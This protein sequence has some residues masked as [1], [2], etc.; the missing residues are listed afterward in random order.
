MELQNNKIKAVA[1][2][3]DLR[4]DDSQCETNCSICYDS[5]NTKNQKKILHKGKNW[6]HKFHK[7]CIDTWIGA[8]INS[9]KYPLCPICNQS[10]NIDKIQ[11]NLRGRAIELQPIQQQPPI[12]QPPIQQHPIQQHPFHQHLQ[13]FEAEADLR[14]QRIELR[15]RRY[16]TLPFIGVLICIDGKVV[17]KYSNSDFG[18]TINSRLGDLK[19]EIL[20]KNAEISRSRGLL[21]VDNLHHN[22]N[23]RN[24][25]NGV[26]PTYRI[27]DMHY[28]IPPFCS[29]FP[30]LNNVNNLYDDNTRLSNIYFEYQTLAG[31]ALSLH[32]QIVNRYGNNAYEHLENVYKLKNLRFNGPT[33]YDD[34]GHYD[35]AYVNNQNPKIPEDM[36]ALRYSDCSTEDSLSWL[37]FDMC[38][39]Y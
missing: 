34:P 17:T 24:W 29:I 9:S 7:K 35:T 3:D 20:L 30:Q 16:E 15:H 14:L 28:G 33:G 26:Y 2:C 21:C 11:K 1:F 39:H 18:L 25:I 32:P 10:I 31:K 6:S 8:N 5:L 36:R 4:S 23:I 13:I 37:V 22:L 38:Q 27:L 12:Q 19:R